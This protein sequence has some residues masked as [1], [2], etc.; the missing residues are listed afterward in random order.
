MN[1]GM[2][3]ALF[4]LGGAALGALGAV[5]LMKNGDKLKPVAA[6]ILSRGMDVRDAVMGKVEAVKEGV[7]DLVAEAHEAAEKRKEAVNS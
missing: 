3:C 6:N 1:E 4:M 2:K 7:E 5:A